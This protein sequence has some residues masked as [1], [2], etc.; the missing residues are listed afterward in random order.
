M[1]AAVAIAVLLGALIGVR[2][3][4]FAHRLTSPDFVAQAFAEGG[5]DAYYFF[6]V[7]RNIAT[8]RGITVDGVHWTTGFQPLWAA[9]CAMAFAF[10]PDRGALALLYAASFACWLAGAWLLVRF[11]R[12]ARGGDL[13]PIA[14][15]L[16]AMLFLAEGQFAQHYVNGMETGLYVTL[17]LALLVA[18]QSHLQGARASDPRLMGLG[19][20]AGLTNACAQ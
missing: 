19:V 4:D 6:T 14:A 18:F 3:F 20:L 9:V 2:G 8:G 5:D 12:S 11:V 17:C 7:A 15:A 16:I 10:A 1:R 13:P